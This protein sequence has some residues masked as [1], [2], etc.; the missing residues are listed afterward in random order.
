VKMAQKEHPSPYLDDRMPVGH[1]GHSTGER[2]QISSLPSA[3][4]CLRR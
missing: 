1:G 4:W 3:W 2:F